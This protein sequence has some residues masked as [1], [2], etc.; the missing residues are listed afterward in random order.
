MVLSLAIVAHL[1]GGQFGWMFRYETYVIV[2]AAAGLCV[3][4]E[5]VG[6][7]IFGLA[8]LVMVIAGFNTLPRVVS[9]YAW[10][11]RAIHL[12]QAQMGRFAGDFLKAP[13]AVNDIGRVS[14]AHD[15]YVL[16]LWGLGS[17]EARRI[18]ATPGI[19]APD[20]WAGD[21]VAR[22][23]IGYALVYDAWI[24]TGIG[25]D[26]RA[27]AHLKMDNPN[28]GIG[29]F[30]VTFYAADAAHEQPLREAVRAFAPT[31]PPDA[32]LTEVPAAP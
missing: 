27:V 2:L 25:A 29:A 19:P 8:A 10:A 5:P 26:W 28:G 1:C 31:L 7:G 14:W 17:A 13:I 11:P 3:L 4:A 6:R 24:G 30:D 21:L 15:P 16:D 20:G 32:H 22:H 9:K 23:G 18:R 12:Q